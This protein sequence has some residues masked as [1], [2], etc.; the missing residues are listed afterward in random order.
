MS[1]E[2]SASAHTVS[3]ELFELHESTFGGDLIPYRHHVHRVLA[4]VSLQVEVEPQLVRPLG[5]AAFFHDASIW[6]D[7][8][9]DYLP[10]SIERAIE[11]LGPDEQEH[12]E[13]VTA[14]SHSQGPTSSP[15]S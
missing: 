9:W 11:E 10:G 7:Q 12:A 8:T 3:N 4:L 1:D 5:V 2:T 15:S 13:L 14:P 6:F